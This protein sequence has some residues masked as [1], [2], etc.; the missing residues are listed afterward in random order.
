MIHQAS[1]T[2][3]RSSPSGGTTTLIFVLFFLSLIIGPNA[4]AHAGSKDF[5]LWA[6]VYLT[7]SL[8]EKVRGWY[9]VQPRFGN[10]ISQINQLLLRTALGYQVTK[11]WS[12]WQGYAWTPS[13]EPGF[14]SENRTFQQILYVHDYPRVNIVSRTRLE[15]RWIQPVRGTAVRFRTLLRGRFPLDDARVW[16]LVV[17]DEIFFNFNSPTNGPE[18]GLDQ[19][20]FF[21]GLNRKINEHMSVDGGYQLQKINTEE[22]EFVDD[23]NHLLLLQFFLNW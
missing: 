16:G 21:L 13:F 10:N 9:E 19:N 20:R 17:Q 4:T 12:L 14:I 6:P 23:F 8:S 7:L 3:N 11:H 15:Q 2:L 18:A 1:K 5:Q 22:P